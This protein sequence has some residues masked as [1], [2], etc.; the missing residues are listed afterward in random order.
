MQD[1]LDHQDVSLIL[2]EEDCAENREE[3]QED[4]HES[5]THC[6]D[7]VALHPC[8]D[9]SIAKQAI[10]SDNKSFKEELAVREPK[11]V[12]LEE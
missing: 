1:E 9:P 6:L 7:S 11:L 3:R 2:K 4:H 12:Q 8:T 5:V 10:E